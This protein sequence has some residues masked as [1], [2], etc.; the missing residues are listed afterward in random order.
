MG[1]H[2]PR[3]IKPEVRYDKN[4]GYCRHGHEKT[5]ENYVLSKQGCKICLRCR[6]EVN[7]RHRESISL[8][9]RF[10]SNFMY[11]KV[12]KERDEL[13]EQLSLL[14]KKYELK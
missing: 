6:D 7:A 2:Y 8:K 4:S 11:Q 13:K 14:I 9:T 3:E 5:P 12:C 10:T 1:S